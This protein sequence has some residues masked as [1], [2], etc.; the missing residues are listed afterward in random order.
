MPTDI[1]FG[2]EGQQYADT[3]K[4]L[5]NHIEMLP[6]SAIRDAVSVDA[7]WHEFDEDREAAL[8]L[9]K[10]IVAEKHLPLE[11]HVSGFEQG[12][13]AWRRICLILIEQLGI[14]GAELR[15]FDEGRAGWTGYVILVD[16][17]PKYWLHKQKTQRDK[18]RPSRTTGR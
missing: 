1:P 13:E 6:K 8:S 7:I 11:D 17:V 12:W 2:P 5:S 10:R 15:R 18:R 3:L 14:P 9:L 16:G 4:H